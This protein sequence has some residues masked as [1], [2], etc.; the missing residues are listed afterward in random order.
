MKKIKFL[1]A[2]FFLSLFFL[3]SQNREWEDLSI[4]SINTEKPH[5][6]FYPFKSEKF[7]L[8]NDIKNNDLF[9]FL[10]GDWD[11]KLYKETKQLM[12]TY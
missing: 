8:E 1:S 7:L 5:A 2:I 11:F 10:N 4:F 9:M 3:Y 12:T 6:T